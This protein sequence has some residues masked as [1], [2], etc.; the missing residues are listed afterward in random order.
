MTYVSRSGSLSMLK[1]G[2]SICVKMVSV[3]KESVEVVALLC[4]CLRYL[5]LRE[6]LP[7]PSVPV[8][9]S[10]PGLFFFA[11]VM[12]IRPFDPPTQPP[13]TKISLVS[14]GQETCAGD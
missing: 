6:C 13:P 12:S 1:D 9:V 4:C 8:L 14:L 5:K 11:F 2:D 10:A 3:R 7:Y